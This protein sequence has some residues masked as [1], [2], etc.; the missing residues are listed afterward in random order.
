MKALIVLTEFWLIACLGFSREHFATSPGEHRLVATLQMDSA[1][2]PG[3]LM[4]CDV[5]ATG[6][7]TLS[8]SIGALPI[9]LL[10]GCHC[11]GSH[12]LCGWIHCFSC[13]L[14]F[15]LPACL[16]CSHL[17]HFPALLMGVG[18]QSMLSLRDWGG[19]CFISVRLFSSVRWLA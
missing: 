1:P 12:C 11:W 17:I 8:N 2:I 15:I 14:V 13:L 19:L 10:L 16:P 6:C 4:K 18:W 7:R 3:M 9:G 5:H